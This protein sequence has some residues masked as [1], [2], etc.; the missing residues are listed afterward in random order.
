MSKRTINSW[1][2]CRDTRKVEGFCKEHNL[3]IVPAK[4]DHV[5]YVHPS[6]AF[7]V[8]MSKREISMGVAM[9]IY[10]F[11]LAMGLLGLIFYLWNNCPA[12]LYDIYI[13]IVG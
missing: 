8:G 6:G 11:F 10:K 13:R 4:G 7:V 1:K 2:D 12:F 9:Q 5:K 3:S